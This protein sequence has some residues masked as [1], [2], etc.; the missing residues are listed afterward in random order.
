MLSRWSRSL[1]HLLTMKQSKQDC[2]RTRSL[3]RFFFRSSDPFFSFCWLC[4]ILL[5]KMTKVNLFKGLPFQIFGKFLEK[6]FPSPF[7]KHIRRTPFLFHLSR[8]SKISW[9]TVSGFRLCFFHFFTN[10]SYW[11]QFRISSSFYIKDLLLSSIPPWSMAISLWRKIWFLCFRSFTFALFCWGFIPPFCEDFIPPFRI[12]WPLIGE[13]IITCLLVDWFFFQ[14]S[15]L[16]PCSPPALRS[17]WLFTHGTSWFFCQ[18]E[19]LFFKFSSL[20][21]VVLLYSCRFYFVISQ[22]AWFLAVGWLGSLRSL[23]LL[24]VV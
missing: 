9:L 2:Q 5:L 3:L 17:S 1:T 10:L 22:L 23:L 13:V 18:I 12:L 19:M 15:C 4:D 7:T 11:H 20:F 24:V 21:V 16:Q 14:P 6:F 8:N